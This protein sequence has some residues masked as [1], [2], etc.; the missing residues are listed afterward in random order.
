MLQ[1]CS[2]IAIVC[3][4]FVRTISSV[5]Q[6]LMSFI[7]YFITASEDHFIIHGEFL[8]K[9]RLHLHAFLPRHISL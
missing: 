4:W 2:L 9:P 3:Y 8:V 6:C 5:E 1:V 7:V